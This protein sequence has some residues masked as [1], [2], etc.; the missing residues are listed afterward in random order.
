MNE[1]NTAKKAALLALEKK[2][3]NIEVYDLRGVSSVTDFF[4]ICTGSTDV[5]C[6]AIENHISTELKKLNIRANH[7]EGRSRGRW[8]LMDYVD[9]VVHIF[10]PQV[11]EYYGLERIWGDVQREI[12]TEENHED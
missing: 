4:V 12:I 10:Q 3:E 11:R 1:K 9:F 2:A 5:Q 7:V 8:I 6:K